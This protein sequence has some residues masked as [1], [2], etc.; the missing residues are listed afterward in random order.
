MKFSL[1]SALVA[2]L[3]MT[4]IIATVSV[5]AT[6]QSTSVTPNSRVA[7]TAPTGPPPTMAE[8]FA[9]RQAEKAS[10]QKAL[11]TELGVTAGRLAEAIDAVKGDR[12]D[13]DVA[14]N[15]LTAAQRTA[16]IACNGAELTC[17]RS[18]L[19]AGRPG[20][21][22]PQGGPGARGGAKGGPGARGE[23]KGPGAHKG[24]QGVK[25]GPRGHQRGLEGISAALALK[26]NI[27]EAA[28]LAALKKLRPAAGGPHGGPQDMPQTGEI[29]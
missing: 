2:A 3:A 19:P 5:G 27:P 29:N 4:A 12:L 13:A 9:K 11:A 24:K 6:K 17:D 14:A 7:N 16:I 10:R 23:A 15:K 26:L 21:R 22:G 1:L 25:G 8:V 28:V 20:Q 18:N